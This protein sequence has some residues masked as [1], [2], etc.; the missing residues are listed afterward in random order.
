VPFSD[1]Q[2]APDGLGDSHQ[3]VVIKMTIEGP[4][5]LANHLRADRTQ[6]SHNTSEEFEQCFH[7]IV[8]AHAAGRRGMEDLK[9]ET[10][11]IYV[12]PQLWPVAAAAKPS[13][14]WESTEGAT[15]SIDSNQRTS[16]STTPS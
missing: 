12:L 1:S 13:S 2:L 16:E 15:F 8:K 9:D 5:P 6:L 7:L 3:H 11:N 14:T 4:R 10:I